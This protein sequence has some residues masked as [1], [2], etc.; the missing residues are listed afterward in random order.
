M[1]KLVFRLNH[2]PDTEADDVRQLLDDHNFDYYE[3]HAGKWGFSVA[4][5]WLKNDDDFGPARQLIDEY[6]KEHTQKMRSEFDKAKAD[7][8]V[9]SFWQLLRMNPLLF[10]AYWLLILIVAGLTIL[11][12]FAFFN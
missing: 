10:T 6:Q 5:I 9:P 8:L 2:V 7:G 1:S 3:T 4:A 12:V 11:P